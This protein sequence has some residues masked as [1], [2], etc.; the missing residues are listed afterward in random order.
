MIE[1]RFLNKIKYLLLA[2]YYFVTPFFQAP[3]WCIKCYRETNDF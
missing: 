2:L 3:A 1:K